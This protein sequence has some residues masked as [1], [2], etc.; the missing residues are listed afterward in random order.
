MNKTEFINNNCIKFIIMA[1]RKSTKK[2]KSIKPLRRSIIKL[3]S[4]KSCGYFT[5][6]TTGVQHNNE[7]TYDDGE[8]IVEDDLNDEDEDGEYVY[9][10]EPY[11]KEEYE[12]ADDEEKEPLKPSLYY[13]NKPPVVYSFINKIRK[14]GKNTKSLVD[15]HLRQM[16][17]DRLFDNNKTFAM[18]RLGNLSNNSSFPILIEVDKNQRKKEVGVI[19]R[20]RNIQKDIG[21]PMHVVRFN[22]GKFKSNNKFR[23]S[24]ESRIIELFNLVEYLWTKTPTSKID[25]YYMFYDGSR[26]N[27][28]QMCQQN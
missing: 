23:L 20:V 22:P 11:S 19:S 15:F 26:I 8:T 14:Q 18:K 21:K 17:P 1:P 28:H 2:T 24:F 3:N 16:G 4:K 13:V 6:G 10:P 9:T 7:I 25:T 27:S 12:F 5:G